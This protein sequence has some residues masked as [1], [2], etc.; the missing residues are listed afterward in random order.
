MKK[1]TPRVRPRLAIPAR[2]TRPARSTATAEAFASGGK[3]GYGSMMPIIGHG[4]D[5]VECDR[6]EDMLRRHGDRFMARVLTNQERERAAQFKNPVQFV[7]GRW[8]AKEAILKMI[9]TGWRGQISWTD[10]EILP[11]DLGRPVVKLGGET[12]RRARELGIETVLLSISHTRG[13]ATASAIGVGPRQP[14]S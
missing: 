6:I 10:M 12:A 8:A 3:P 1:E 14:V 2:S 11:D 5:L 13:H 4:I 9:G 7:A